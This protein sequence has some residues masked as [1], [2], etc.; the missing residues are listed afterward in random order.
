M[1]PVKKEA[2]DGGWIEKARE[3]RSGGGRSSSK[4]W[5]AYQRPMARQRR[6][7]VRT[8]HRSTEAQKRA[9]AQEIEHD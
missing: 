8:T 9:V 3:E 4:K 7:V 6:E 2:A 1:I 5:V